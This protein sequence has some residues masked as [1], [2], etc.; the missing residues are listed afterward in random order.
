MTPGCLENEN[1]H[2][3]VVNP[4]VIFGSTMAQPVLTKELV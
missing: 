1:L 3:R 2:I 4:D